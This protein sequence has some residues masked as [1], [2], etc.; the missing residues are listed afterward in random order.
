MRKARSWNDLEPFMDKQVKIVTK[1]GSS[2]P[3]LG[4]VTSGTGVSGCFPVVL[5][6]I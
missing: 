4:W 6:L 2:S 5:L 1:P 3:F